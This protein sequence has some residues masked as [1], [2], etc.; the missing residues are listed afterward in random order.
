MSRIPITEFQELA[1][2]PC[3][4]EVD[5]LVPL[6]FRT[7][8]RP[9]GAEY[10]RLGNH[11]TR[12]AEL[13]IDPLSHL[14]RGATLTLFDSFAP[15]VA[16][17]ETAPSRG[18]PRLLMQNATGRRID[19]NSDFSVSMKD[20]ELLLTWDDLA[21]VSKSSVYGDVQFL[22]VGDNLSGIRFFDLSPE[23]VSLLSRFPKTNLASRAISLK[24][25]SLLPPRPR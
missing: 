17:N 9:I 2:V 16:P 21:R 8:D 1:G 24:P 22:L 4:V 13:I 19:A 5:E 18:L 6:R 11:S 15:W 25:A 3:L 23:A 10:L 14:L 12:L 7:Y 20:N